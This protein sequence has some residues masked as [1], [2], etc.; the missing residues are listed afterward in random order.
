MNVRAMIR[1]PKREVQWG[2]TGFALDCLTN[3]G[4]REDP[5]C[6]IEIESVQSLDL[7]SEVAA[8]TQNRRALVQKIF[9]GSFPSHGALE[10][11]AGSFPDL[12]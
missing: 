5:A 9:Q 2:R 7:A 6:R 4:H 11:Q 1:S 8:P 12:F 10:F 3:C